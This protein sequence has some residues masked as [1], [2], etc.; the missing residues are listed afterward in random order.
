MMATPPFVAMNFENGVL[1]IVGA[2]L[3]PSSNFVTSYSIT[4]AILN[5]HPERTG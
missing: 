1:V 4:S 2:S 5:S 3:T